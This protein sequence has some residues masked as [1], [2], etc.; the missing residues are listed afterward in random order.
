VWSFG[1]RARR[2]DRIGLGSRSDP[3]RIPLG[4]R[5]DGLGSRIGCFGFYDGIGLGSAGIG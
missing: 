1:L 2:A 4:S 3:A 5:S